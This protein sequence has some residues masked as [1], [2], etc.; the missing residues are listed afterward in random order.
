MK[1]QHRSLDAIGQAPRQRGIV[2]IDAMVAILIFSVGILGMVAL[3]GSAVEMTSAA[4]YRL[5]AAMLADQV[6]AQMWTDTPA[7]IAGDFKGSKG[8]GGSNYIAWYTTFSD[9]TQT[10]AATGCL[11]GVKAHPPSI[12]VTSQTIPSSGNT[13]YQVT[14]TV[15]WQA[16]SDSSVHKYVSVTSI[17]Y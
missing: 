1:K 16:P 11:P 8:D 7:N 3:Q 2:L 12:S 9:C 4:N 6:I 10:T 14:V 13:Q 15:Y 17:G 5:N